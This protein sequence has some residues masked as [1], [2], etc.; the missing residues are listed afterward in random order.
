VSDTVLGAGDIS[1]EKRQFLSLRNLHS[2]DFRDEKSLFFI[3]EEIEPQT[4][5]MTL[6]TFTE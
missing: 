3:H 5:I 1:K 6:P 4:D 2:N